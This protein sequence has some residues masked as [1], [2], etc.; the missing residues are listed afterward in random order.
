M[1]RIDQ[2]DMGKGLR[3][4]SE[5]T[6]QDGIVFLGQQANVVAQIEQT[7]EQI[8]RLLSA[9]GKGIVVG[10]PERARQKR[11]LTRR[12]AVD[13][14]LRRVPEHEAFVDKFPLDRSNG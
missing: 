1:R 8:A 9:A 2:R 7:Q 12:E 11:P 3:K 13:A 5:L 6:T 4:I 10:K 14:S